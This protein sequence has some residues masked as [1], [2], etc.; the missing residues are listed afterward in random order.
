MAQANILKRIRNVFQPDYAQPVQRADNMKDLSS[1]ISPVQLTRIM[2]DVQILRSALR[3]AEQA[4]YPHRVKLQKMYTD[5]ILNGHVY[6]CLQRRED[7]TMLRHWCFKDDKGVENEDYKKEINK[8]WFDKFLRE[9]IKAQW[10][11][12]SLIALGELRN[13]EFP[14]LK[15]IKR[16]DV[17]PD[18]L[19][20]TRFEYSISGTPFLTGPAAPWHVWIP[21][22][23][24]VGESPCGY[25]L[26]FTIALY[27]ILA[28]HLMGNNSDAAELYGM[29]IRIGR[30]HKLELEERQN[31]L[32]ALVKMGTAGA[33][34][35]DAM[36]ELELLEP[37]GNGAGFRIYPDLEARLFKLIS[38][39]ILGHADALD[40]IPG[41]L[42]NST[43]Q[44]PA[45]Q[46]LTDKQINDGRFVENIVNGVL[47]PKLNDLG[48][49]FDSRFRFTFSNNQELIEKRK[50]ED[51]NND[52]TAG[53]V[54]KLFQSGLAVDPSYVSE[55]TGIPVTKIKE[56]PTG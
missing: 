56:I 26:L 14:E 5:T 37:K 52:L 31:F 28:R 39:I 13:S 48:F 49:N 27:E 53:I 36:D 42:G 33:I 35:M 50:N 22:D 38:K 3:E 51:L 34:V 25:G 11:G 6:A 2:G 8:P 18:R 12:Y 19:N 17:S 47:I 7:L 15:T 55:R 23:S 41:K 43:A 30:T 29:P 32:D 40:S 16:R 21:T 9:A 20:V 4:W 24:D 10:F 54:L 44:S 1:T 46:A 45:E